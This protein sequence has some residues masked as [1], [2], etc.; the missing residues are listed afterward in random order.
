MKQLVVVS[1]KGGTGK[2]VLSASFAALAGG[3]VLADVDVDASN[4]HLLLRPEIRERHDFA[5]GAKAR[6]DA[7]ACSAC[8]RCLPLCRFEAVTQDRAGIARVD[9]FACEGCGLCVRVCPASAI[10][11]EPGLA[12]EWFVSETR[13]GPLVH[14]RLGVAQENSGKLVTVV[15]NKALE[16]GEKDGRG[17][18][19]MD[20]SPGIGC[21][22]IASLSGADLALVVTEP[23]PSGVHDLERIA[24]LAHHFGVRTACVV[25]RFDLNPAQAERIASGCAAQGIAVLGRVPF[26]A[27][28]MASV[29]RGLPLVEWSEG[30]AAREVRGLWA[31]IKEHLA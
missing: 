31:R 8:G 26:D 1:G 30:P 10:A 17:L 16:I 27:E 18:L 15:R 12:G 4:L 25:N 23:T 20:G 3:A 19:I 14:A 22:V 7:K 24:G 2:T 28:V 13:F 29:A 11:M 5:G 9:R 6:V 21:P